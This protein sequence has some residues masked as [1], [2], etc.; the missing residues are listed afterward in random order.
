MSRKATTCRLCGASRC[1][2]ISPALCLT[3]SLRTVYDMEK[4][5]AIAAWNRRGG[6]QCG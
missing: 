1:L 3:C 5:D 2:S 4:A 6:M